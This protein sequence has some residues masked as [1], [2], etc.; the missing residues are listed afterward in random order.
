M[1][2]KELKDWACNIHNDSV[3]QFDKGYTFP[4]WEALPAIKLRAF[5]ASTSSP[6]EA[7]T[8]EQ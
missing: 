2:G 6:T 7:T 4:N 5:Y 3:I 1:T 8:E